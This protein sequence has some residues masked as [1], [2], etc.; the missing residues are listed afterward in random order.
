VTITHKLLDAVEAIRPILSEGV[1][2]AETERVPTSAGYQAMYDAGLF[3][4]LAPR[5]YGGYELHP[6]E[7]LRVWEAVALIDASSVW[8]LVMNQGIANYAA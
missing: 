2:R 1:Q 3:A 8:N 6:T 4:M 5:R 7:C